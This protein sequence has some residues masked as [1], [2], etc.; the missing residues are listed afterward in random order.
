MCLALEA[1]RLGVCEGCK[2]NE[3]ASIREGSRMSCSVLPK[4]VLLYCCR[5]W[6][7]ALQLEIS[8]IQPHKER[9]QRQWGWRQRMHKRGLGLSGQQ[10]QGK[11]NLFFSRVKQKQILWVITNFVLLMN[12]YE[13]EETV[14]GLSLG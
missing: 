4:A 9:M 14:R 3:T 13:Y 11:H 2:M 8:D 5:P 12:I 6:F 1:H 7:T 10:V